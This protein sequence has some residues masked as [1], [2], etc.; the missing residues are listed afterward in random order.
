MA[1]FS[2]VLIE[3]LGPT[4]PI[5]II[6]SW[7]IMPTHP[8]WTPVH[9]T[10]IVGMLC[11][12]TIS[13]IVVSG[14]PRQGRNVSY[15]RRVTHGSLSAI[16]REALRF[17]LTPA[18]VNQ[19]S[20]IGITTIPGMMTGAILV[21]HAASHGYGT[22]GFTALHSSTQL[23]TA[24]TAPPRRH[25]A[26]SICHDQDYRTIS[27]I[28]TRL[29]CDSRLFSPVLPGSPVVI[30]THQDVPNVYREY[31]TT[32]LSEVA[33]DRK[34]SPK[35]TEGL[36]S[37]LAGKPNPGTFPFT[38]FSCTVSSPMDDSDIALKLDST[39]LAQ[40]LQY[41]TTAGYLNLSDWLIR[42]QEHSHSRTKSADWSLLVGS[43]SQVLIFKAVATLIDPADPVLV[44]SSAYASR[45]RCARNQ[46]KFPEIKFGKLACREAKATRPV[47]RSCKPLLRL[48]MF[49]TEWALTVRLQPDWN[50]ARKF[51]H[52]LA[53]TI[54]SSFSK[55]LIALLDVL[56]DAYSGCPTDDPYYFLYYGKA[57][58]YPSYFAL[59]SEEPETG[60]VL[61]FDSLSKV[62]S[63]GIRIGFVSGPTPLL[64]AINARDTFVKHT[65]K[66]AQF[67]RRKRDVFEAVMNK[68]LSGL[69][70]W[71]S[72]E[73]G[74]LF[75][76]KLVLSDDSSVG[77]QPSCSQAFISEK[78]VRQGILALP[79]TTFL[80]NGR[81]SAYVRASFS[82]LGEQ[83][84]DEALRRL[85]KVILD[86]RA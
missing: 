39:E 43:G 18:A 47:H 63:A 16:A 55:V 10:P 84:V 8:F 6:G 75:W 13:G 31:Y 27:I 35:H 19:M 60:R 21:L 51:L 65:Q 2:S 20:V 40:G 29:Y 36:I 14:K 74:I 49:T 48:N 15:L 33:K 69:G 34:P 53:N 61:R 56:V 77:V 50:A 45:N 26:F 25:T 62:L 81:K 70:Q 37:L 78:A 9:Y 4:I 54:S 64:R 57:T 58:R 76:F 71:D 11:G 66:V 7:F 44:E 30:Q 38:S 23:L 72:P 80:P 42:L 12:S 3:M 24:H 32:F 59:E 86:S 22:H 83:D 17:A 28:S 68:R 1:S 73:A 85:A 52:S 41:G 82:L 46:V 79:G 67:Y 5:P